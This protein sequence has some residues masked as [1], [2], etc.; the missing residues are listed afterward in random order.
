MVDLAAKPFYLSAQDIAWVRQTIESM[1]LEEKVGPTV[2]RD[3]QRR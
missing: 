2:Y 1:T 3:E